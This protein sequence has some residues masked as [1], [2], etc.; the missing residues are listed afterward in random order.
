M[1]V[2]GLGAVPIM[3]LNML[4]QFAALMLLSGA[5]YL[6]VFT[7]DQLQAL[8]LLFLDFHG[9]GYFIA[10]MFSGLFL[11]PLGYL[12]FKS[13]FVPRLLGI[14]VMI[15]CFGYL[16]E[17]LVIFVVPSYEIISYLG[18]A[19]AIIAEFSLTFWLLVK[20]ITVESV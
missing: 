7:P 17:L 15:G 13:G 4:N 19:V 12:F 3:M 11:L 6:T 8:A 16:L 1:L 2:F 18:L 20:G 9:Q 5:D 14:L 10:G